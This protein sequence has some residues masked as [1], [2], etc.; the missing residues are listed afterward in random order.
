MSVLMV[1][2]FCRRVLHDQLFR[3]LALAHPEKAVADFAFSDEERRAL[4][5]GDVAHLHQMGATPFLLLIFSRFEIFGLSLDIYN[6]RMRELSQK[7]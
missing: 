5:E 2:K 1:H 3:E 6:A 4:L 7:A